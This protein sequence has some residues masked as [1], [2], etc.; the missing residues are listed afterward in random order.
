MPLTFFLNWKQRTAGKAVGEAL[1]YIKIYIAGVG[2]KTAK[3]YFKDVEE[4]VIR[5]QS[6]VWSNL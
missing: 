6:K 1:Q 5:R 2:T 3:E 4:Q